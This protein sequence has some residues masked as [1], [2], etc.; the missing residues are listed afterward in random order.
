MSIGPVEAQEQLRILRRLDN[1]H[2]C[3]VKVEIHQFGQQSVERA[4]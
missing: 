3:A 2:S 4:F 1:W